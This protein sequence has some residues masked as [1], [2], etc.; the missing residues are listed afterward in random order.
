MIKNVGN[1]AALIGNRVINTYYNLRALTHSYDGFVLGIYEISN[2]KD[3][4]P[5]EKVNRITCSGKIYCEG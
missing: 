2:N 5:I 3:K 1:G 4:K